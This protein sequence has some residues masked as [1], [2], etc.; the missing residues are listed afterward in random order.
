[1]FGL[2]EDHFLYRGPD[3]IGFHGRMI[4]GHVTAMAPLMLMMT[5]CRWSVDTEMLLLL[6]TTT[7]AHSHTIHRR[8]SM[9]RRRCGNRTTES[10]RCCPH[11][12]GWMHHHYD[13]YEVNMIRA[14]TTTTIRTFSQCVYRYIGISLRR[15]SVDWLNLEVDVFFRWSCA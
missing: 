4:T 2:I 15:K 12:C 3:P 14:R 13:I 5:Y 10:R 8:T 1:M 9:H 11:F 6:W 7:N